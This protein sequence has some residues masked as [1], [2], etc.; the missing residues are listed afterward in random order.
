VLRWEV[1]YGRS[2]QLQVSNDASTWSNVYSTTTGDGGVDDITLAI[3][4]SGRY[5]RMIGT[6]RATR[7]GYSLYEFEIYG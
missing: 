2:Y 3:P 6:V 5:V 4:A 7:Y 1:A